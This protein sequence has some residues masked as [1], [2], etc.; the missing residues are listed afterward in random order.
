MQQCSHWRLVGDTV[1]QD[2]DLKEQGS[3]LDAFAETGKHLLPAHRRLVF[4]ATLEH[5]V[6]LHCL[7]EQ[8]LGN[9][10]WWRENEYVVVNGVVIVVAVKNREGRL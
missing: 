8:V 5:S 3:D 2:Y 4:A 10:R 7:Y 6:D 9:S 1:A